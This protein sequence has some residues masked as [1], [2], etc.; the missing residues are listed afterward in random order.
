MAVS[1]E[2][3]AQIEVRHEILWDGENRS[4]S[5]VAN[6]NL[7]FVN[8]GPP[9]NA[10]DEAVKNRVMR[11]AESFLSGMLTQRMQLHP[12]SLAHLVIKCI[13]LDYSS[14]LLGFD[15][16]AIGGAAYFFVKDYPDL[17]RG[18][19]EITNDL[20]A[21]GRAIQRFILHAFGTTADK[22]D[23]VPTRLPRRARSRSPR[24][25]GMS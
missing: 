16:I 14:I 6:I 17:R 4:Q 13:R 19:I 9:E 5:I 24:A 20:K 2:N 3:D 23:V 8:V 15:F 25:P 10:Y 21:S 1:P 18:V 12:N 22:R 11:D 7:Q